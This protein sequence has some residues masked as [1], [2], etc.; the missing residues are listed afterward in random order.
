MRFHI[1]VA[2]ALIGITGASYTA[3]SY[4]SATCP[5][6]D[7]KYTTLFKQPLV[8]HS[9]EELSAPASTTKAIDGKKVPTRRRK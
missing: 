3:L 9:T 1:L 4:Q 6:K 2:A 5:L 8:A 7:G